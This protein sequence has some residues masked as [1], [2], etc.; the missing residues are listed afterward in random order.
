MPVKDNPEPEVNS[1]DL[2]SRRICGYGNQGY[3]QNARQE[4]PSHETTDC[5][6]DHAYH[7]SDEE[8]FRFQV[9][10]MMLG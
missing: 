5:E 9:P 4:L 1:V 2:K 3:T 8:A 10:V 6:L 7:I